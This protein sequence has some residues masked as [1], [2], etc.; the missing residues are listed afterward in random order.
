MTDEAVK[1][2]VLKHDH[3]IESL[4]KSVEDLVQSNIETNKSL[5][6]ISQ[7]L[8]KQAVLDT[9]LMSLD[10]ELTESFQRVHG[11]IDNLEITQNSTVGCKSVQLLH[12]DVETLAHTVN[13]LVMDIKET[14]DI[15]NTIND[16]VDEL[17]SPR[18]MMWIG[19]ILIV[20]IVSFGS[21]VVNKIHTTEITNTAIGD[22][23]E[24]LK[25]SNK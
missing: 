22:D 15:Q 23:V 1:E 3:T 7:Y 12:K 25:R 8:A 9:K 11:R 18:V 6:E 13:Q 20:Y 21:Y 19:G 2:L 17:P 16:K 24:Y 5:K 10:R 4:V 14:K